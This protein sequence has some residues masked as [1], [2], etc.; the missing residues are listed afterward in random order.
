MVQN[1]IG[2]GFDAAPEQPPDQ[3]CVKEVAD[4]LER[5]ERILE[6][7]ER[8]LLRSSLSKQRRPKYGIH[9]NH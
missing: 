4:L 8:I 3:R 7:T 1:L 6:C 2:N 9:P 5:M